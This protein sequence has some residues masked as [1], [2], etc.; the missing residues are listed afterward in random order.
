MHKKF[1]YS[2]LYNT[3]DTNHNQFGIY[4]INSSHRY[5][6]TIDRFK[7]SNFKDKYNETKIPDIQLNET[8]FGQLFQIFKDNVAWYIIYFLVS[9]FYN[10][11]GLIL[12]KYIG[13]IYKASIGVG[14]LSIL[15]IRLG[16]L[17][18]AIVFLFMA[19]LLL[20]S[21]FV[22]KLGIMTLFKV[23]EEHTF[24]ISWSLRNCGSI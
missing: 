2:L 23:V 14:R 10:L 3:R 11:V 20:L 21:F 24:F 8:V 17:I 22:F 7:A 5:E 19:K 6:I 1:F 16:F 15:L 18:F 9:I 4:E 13:E 12:S